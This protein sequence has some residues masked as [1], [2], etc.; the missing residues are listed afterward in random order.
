LKLDHVAVAVA[1]ADA[2]RR[3]F[4]DLLGLPVVH[5]E[6]VEDQGVRVVALDMGESRLELTEPL[7]EDTPVG[8]FL[9]KRGQGLH[10]LALNVPDL[11]ATLARLEESG[12]EL[13]DREPR[14]GAEGKLIAFLH[15]RS[16]GGVLVELSQ[17]P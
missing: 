12:V 2:A 4:S 14:V 7:G 9:A 5:E 17:T 11:K 16:T 13:I 6:T 8:R 1:D 10:H 3:V 15:P